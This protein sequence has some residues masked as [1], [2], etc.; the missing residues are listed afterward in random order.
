MNLLDL[1]KPGMPTME[2]FRVALESGRFP[3]V[4]AR[5]LRNLIAECFAPRFLGQDGRNAKLANLARPVLDRQALVQLFLVFACRAN[6][7]LHD[8][9]AT[10]YWGAY[11]S[12]R[13]I[14]SKGMALEFVDRAVELGRTTTR[15]SESVRS[16]VAGYLT[17]A[18]AD[19]GLLEHSTRSDRE[20]RPFRIDDSVAILLA[21]DL[22]FAGL[23]D[24]AVAGHPDW[25]VFG[26][27]RGDVV[28]ILRRLAPRGRLIVQS[29]G[30]SIDVSWTC[31][32][33][34]EVCDAL[35]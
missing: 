34:E 33:M 11:S 8:F 29:A 14:V 3:Q 19:F 23:G 22:H 25:S 28:S 24:N 2:L 32:N 30:D 21:H 27:E 18:C 20:I 1:W 15:W 7:I 5:R 9:L 6:T 10:V 16:R 31:K 12:G 4:T 13:T 35:A 17:G 26:L